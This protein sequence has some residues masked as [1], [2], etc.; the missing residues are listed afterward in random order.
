MIPSDVDAVDALH[1]TEAGEHDIYARAPQMKVIQPMMAA[2]HAR[3]QYKADL[4]AGGPAVKPPKYKGPK[5]S[6]QRKTRITKFFQ[7][8]NSLHRA[9]TNLP[10]RKDTFVRQHGGKHYTNSD[11]LV[12][13]DHKLLFVSHSFWP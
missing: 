9:T 2:Q 7:H 10:D 12:S 13:I 3:K 4:K 6:N 5:L 1:E 8:A 11:A